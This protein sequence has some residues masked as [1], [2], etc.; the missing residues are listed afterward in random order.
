[1]CETVLRIIIRDGQDRIGNNGRARHVVRPRYSNSLSHDAREHANMRARGN[2]PSDGQRLCLPDTVNVQEEDASQ[3]MGLDDKDDS[4][5]DDGASAW[6]SAQAA[7]PPL[8]VN[9]RL[10]RK[11]LGEVSLEDDHLDSVR[12][13][14]SSVGGQKIRP[15][16][17]HTP[18]QQAHFHW[19]RSREGSSVKVHSQKRSCMFLQPYNPARR[20]GTPEPKPRIWVD[21]AF[22][23]WN[24]QI[25][26]APLT[27]LELSGSRSNVLCSDQAAGG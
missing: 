20:T 17:G 7:G 11:I 8:H 21:R 24:D 16:P 10:G 15:Q 3:D 2:V 13:R 5:I 12:S 26:V 9:D 22:G 23:P 19:H 1:L 25:A 14:T 18:L 27:G 6:C 4:Q